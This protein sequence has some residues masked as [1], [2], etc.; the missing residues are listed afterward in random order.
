MVEWFYEVSSL[1][2]ENNWELGWKCCWIDTLESDSKLIIDFTYDLRFE[3]KYH[4]DGVPWMDLLETMYLL[5]TGSRT[6]KLLY[7]LKKLTTLFYGVE[8]F[9]RFFKRLA[10]SFI[11]INIFLGEKVY[12]INCT[13]VLI[14]NHSI[15]F[16]KLFPFL[17]CFF[18]SKL[19]SNSVI[20]KINFLELLC[21]FYMSCQR[22]IFFFVFWQVI[23]LI[24]IFKLLFC[25]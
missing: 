8:K 21:I 4:V 14:E 16:N 9:W 6:S 23:F 18:I 22:L 20:R 12:L 5:D 17:K 25:K 13:Y 10:E 1:T 11:K 19:P 7:S 3:S 15:L 2:G 24:R